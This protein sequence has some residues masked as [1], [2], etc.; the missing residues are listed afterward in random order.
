MNKQ[1]WFAF[2]ILLT[3]IGCVSCGHR[4]YYGVEVDNKGKETVVFEPFR[5]TGGKN[6][7]VHVGYVNPGGGEVI[8][9]S[10]QNRIQVLA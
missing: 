5:I 6:G 3:T 8:L 9:R 7:I 1:V 10:T 2:L 4:Y